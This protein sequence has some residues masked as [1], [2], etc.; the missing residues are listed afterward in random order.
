MGAP[1]QD[2]G[3]HPGTGIPTTH[4]VGTAHALAPAEGSAGRVGAV[5]CGCHGV[6][7]RRVLCPG[8]RAPALPPASEA[9][10]GE[11]WGKG[12]VVRAGELRRAAGQAPA[13][14][15][16][17]I[18][19]LQ[20]LR[21]KRDL[22]DLPAIQIEYLILAAGEE[23]GAQPWAHVEV[24]ERWAQGCPASRGGISRSQ[25]KN[26]ARAVTGAGGIGHPLPN[27]P[28]IPRATRRLPTV[29]HSLCPTWELPWDCPGMKHGH[30]PSARDAP[31]ALRRGPG[32]HGPAR[33]W[34]LAA[35]CLTALP[36]CPNKAV[37]NKA[38]PG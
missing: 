27:L 19:L 26:D 20:E 16:P 13:E 28:L 33:S 10:H 23:A 14:I 3:S 18:F 29:R 24:C 2:H 32:G 25:G 6:L 4:G 17:L 36:P 30:S 1:W 35:T 38:V 31:G 12:S 8:H 7:C 15:T 9:S 22:Q 11:T 37:P 34:R 21:D 5:G